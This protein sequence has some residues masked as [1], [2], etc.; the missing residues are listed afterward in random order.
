MNR[1]LA[2]LVAALVFASTAIAPTA[3]GKAME[4]AAKP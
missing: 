1:T 2:A 3:A 4:Q